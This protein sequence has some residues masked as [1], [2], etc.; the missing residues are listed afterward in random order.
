MDKEIPRDHY[1]RCGT[2]CAAGGPALHGA[3]LHR[4]KDGTISLADIYTIRAGEMARDNAR[5]RL[6]V[7]A[8][9]IVKVRSRKG[10]SACIFYDPEFK[11]C[12]IYESRPLEC[13][14][15]AC[16]DTSE[17]IAVYEKDRITRADILCR[18]KEVLELVRSHEKKCS[19]EKIGRLAER[20]TAGDLYA[21]DELAELVAFDA[22]V[23]SLV[24]SQFDYG[25]KIL[26]FLFGRPLHVTIPL[27]FGIKIESKS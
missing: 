13:R 18:A 10:D 24:S 22:S 7:L 16:W 3:D 9:E 14:A 27:Q 20:R 4:L 6:R 1:I 2:C 8:V 26:D 17:I 5:D 25:K 12:E 19:Y 23:R 11:T 21:A 15:M